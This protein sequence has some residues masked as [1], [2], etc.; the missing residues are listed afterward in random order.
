MVWR[1]T[2]GVNLTQRNLTF[3]VFDSRLM[4]FVSFDILSYAAGLTPITYARFLLATLFGMLPISF[5]LAHF[6]HELSSADQ[7]RMF[8]TIFLLGF[9][10]VIPFAVKAVLV[11][12]RANQ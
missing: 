2:I 11:K 6:G 7:T 8:V 9:I 3:I 1:Q 5:L 4:P 12:I 10:T